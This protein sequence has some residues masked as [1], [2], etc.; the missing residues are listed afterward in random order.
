MGVFPARRRH[1]AVLDLRHPTPERLAA[2]L[3]AVG[4]DPAGLLRAFAAA[5]KPPGTVAYTAAE[6]VPAARA[7]ARE[8]RYLA[9]L[10]WAEEPEE[11]GPWHLYRGLRLA[12][13]T[14]GHPWL[15]LAK[16]AD[17]RSEQ[18]LIA[19]C[20]EVPPLREIDAFWRGH[21]HRR[22]GELLLLS[23]WDAQRGQVWGIDGEGSPRVIADQ[24]G[25]RPLS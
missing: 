3:L 14:S 6:H 2:A 7:D 25:V 13:I 8:G 17:L 22:A 10:V 12:L 15:G 23:A 18:R 1:P 5:R 9:D 24:K 16:L 19:C 11:R 21:R 4:P 20:D